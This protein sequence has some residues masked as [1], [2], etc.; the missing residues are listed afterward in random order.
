[1]E[2]I[3]IGIIGVGGIANGA[4][5][6]QLQKCSN[7]KIT[8][9]CD[10][11]EARLKTIGD[12][13]GI[14][15]ELRFK[16]HLDL[17]ASSEVDAVEICTPNYLHIDMALDVIKSGKPVE[18]E[19]PLDIDASKADKLLGLLEEK[20]TPNM[21]CFSYRFFPAVRYAK[22]ILEEGMLGDIVNVNIEYLKDSAFM[23]GRRLEWR[24]V[25]EYA[26]SGVLGDLGVHLIDMTRFLLG[27]FKSVYAMKR[28]VIDKRQKLDSEE[29]APVETDDLTSF[30]AEMDTGVIANFIASRCALGNGNTIKYEIYGT[31]GVI[32][33][34]LNNP[35]ELGV[36]VGDIDVESGALHTV[37]V[38]G[39]YCPPSQEQTFV[40]MVSGKEMKYLPTIHDGVVSQRIVDAV[41]KSSE[42]KEKVSL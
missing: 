37:K 41:L 27:E 2:K 11:D 10:N 15:E 38:P 28:I 36:C 6:P 4:H 26:G 29:Y 23:K 1:M 16:N 33:F 13:L 24:F 14:P 21:M 9:I 39:A 30:I 31:K 32:A 35:S 20:K 12:K 5:I 34:N 40:D 17:I 42:I 25:K 3:R 7:A 22:H 19:K 18:V 8:A